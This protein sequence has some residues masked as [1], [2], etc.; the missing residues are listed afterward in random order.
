MC[1]TASAGRIRTARIAGT[2]CS[3][4]PGDTN[5]DGAVDVVDLVN[6]VSSW[7]SSGEGDGYDADLDGSGRVDVD[8]LVLVIT[9]WGVC[10]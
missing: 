5:G 4:C 1:R 8:D 10:P 9:S 2:I 3:S 7:G 6:V